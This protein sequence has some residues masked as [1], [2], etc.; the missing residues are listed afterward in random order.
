MTREEALTRTSFLAA[1]S[2][3]LVL[4]DNGQFDIRRA[5]ETGGIHAMKKVKVRNFTRRYKDGTVEDVVTTEVEL[6]DKNGSLELMGKHHGLWT[7]EIDD[8]DEVL[9]RLLG[10]PKTLLPANLDPDPN[11]GAVDGDLVDE[12]DEI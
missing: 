5:R 12:V 7:D 2:L 4:D 1:A 10:I 3:D 6:H 8:P 11:A 9:S